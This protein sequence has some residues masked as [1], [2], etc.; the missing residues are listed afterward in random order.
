MIWE[1]ARLRRQLAGRLS[2][3]GDT[4]GSV[5]QLHRV[6]ATWVRL[7]ARDELRKVEQMYEELGED[8]PDH[9]ST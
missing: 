9:P 6:H 7:G 4:E 1:A 8:P 3:I 5:A 2:D